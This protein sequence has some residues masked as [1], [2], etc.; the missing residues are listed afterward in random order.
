MNDYLILI[1]ILCFG[2]GAGIAFWLKGRILS[3]KIKSAEGEAVKILEESKRRS[4]TLIKEANLEVKDRLFKMKSDFDTETK[5][6]RSELQ[7]REKRLIQKEA[8]TSVRI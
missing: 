6:T 4:E 3:Q 5:E 2:A 7:K 8:T 1:G